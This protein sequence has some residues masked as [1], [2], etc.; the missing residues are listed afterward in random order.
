MKLQEYV[1]TAALWS[2]GGDLQRG[3]ILAFKYHEIIMKTNHSIIDKL[4]NFE[5]LAGKVE[6]VSTLFLALLFELFN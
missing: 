2:A 6:F 1:T 4:V 5:T 3:P